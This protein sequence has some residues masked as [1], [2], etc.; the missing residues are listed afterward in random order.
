M[1]DVSPGGEEGTAGAGGDAGGPAPLPRYPGESVQPPTSPVGPPPLARRV[2][3]PPARL[4]PV[5]PGAARLPPSGQAPPGYPPPGQAPPGYPP[6]GNVPP[7]YPPGGYAP[8][9]YPTLTTPYATYGAR[10]GGWLIDF[11]LLAVVGLIIEIPLRAD[12]LQR[13]TDSRHTVH[14]HQSPLGIVISAAIA[15]LYGGILCGSARGQTVGMMVMKTRAV[16]L[17]GG[18]PLG[19]WRATGR[20]A[21]E[22]LLAILL[23]VPWIVDMLW[24]LWDSRNQT[25]HDKISGTVVIPRPVTPPGGAPPSGG[26][27]SAPPGYGPFGYGQ[28]GSGPLN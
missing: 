11:V 3:C 26:P 14:L 21:F 25:L 28:P 24:P 8:T 2:R 22:Y 19:F 12:R 20:A 9:G 15:I 18:A 6:S 4:P 13:A 10:L 1:S 17:A 23:L 16:T 7:G 27:T 5:R